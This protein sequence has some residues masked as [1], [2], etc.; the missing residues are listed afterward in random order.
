MTQYF[1]FLTKEHTGGYS[2]FDWTPYLPKD[3]QPGE[4]TPAIEGELVDCRNGYHLCD[5]TQILG[6]YVQ[7]EMYEAEYVEIRPCADNDKHIQSLNRLGFDVGEI[8]LE[9]TD[10]GHARVHLTPK[11]VDAGHHA[12]R[13]L[14]LTGL[15]VEEHQAQ[16]LLN[17]LDAFHAEVGN[18]ESEE[19]VSHR[20]V[21]EMF[22]PI[23]MAVPHELRRKLEPAQIFH[24]VLENRWYMSEQAGEDVGLEAATAAYISQILARKPDEMALLGTPAGLD[25]TQ[26][27]PIVDHDLDGVPFDADEDEDDL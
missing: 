12:R 15:D 26:E 27:I 16:R 7:A 11:V 18:D 6:S 2:N 14:R 20:W 4:W 17:D 9:A 21:S 3:G 25:D 22:E 13:L 24:E 1:K 19:V 8:R 10:D 23:V 5:E